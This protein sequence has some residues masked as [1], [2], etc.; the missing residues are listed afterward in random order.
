MPQFDAG[1]ASFTKG[2]DNFAAILRDGEGVTNQRA[3]EALGGPAGVQQLN[4]T[5]SVGGQ[6]MVVRLEMAGRDLGRAV[7]D[8]MRAGR[9]LS[10]HLTQG[11]RVGVRPVFMGK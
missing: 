6:S 8:E 10:R 4:Q 3:T 1:F 5:G 2:P 9:E 7:V 11:R